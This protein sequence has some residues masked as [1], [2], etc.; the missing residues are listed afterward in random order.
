[1]SNWNVNSLRTLW[2]KKLKKET[3][4]PVAFVGDVVGTGSSRKSGINSVQ[5][6][7]GR[8]IPGVPN[9]RTGGVI[10]GSIIAPIF[11]N[12]AGDSGALPIQAPVDELE[13]GDVITIK[14][15]EGKILKD[16]KVVSEFELK[17]NTLPDEVRAG[18]RIPLIIG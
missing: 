8:D 2:I 3:G 17:P 13:T 4:L 11:F 9:K 10:I 12:T 18:G 1:M 16:G 5:W 7:I 6:H 15:Y 14:P